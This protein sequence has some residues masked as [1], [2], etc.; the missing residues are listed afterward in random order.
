MKPIGCVLAMVVVLGGCAGVETKMVVIS[1]HA[2]PAS[3]TFTVIPVNLQDSE[4]EQAVRI[5]EC[6]LAAG[7][8]VLERP[9]VQQVEITGETVAGKGKKRSSNDIVASFDA[10][11][12]DV[13]LVSNYA[14]RRV[15]MLLSGQDYRVLLSEVYEERDP[16][17]ACLV[18]RA[19]IDAYDIGSAS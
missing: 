18:V 6:L 19:A 5:Q 3:P 8:V 16:S 9:A 10:T 2:L 7:L 13:L 4:V 17:S 15:R 14:T 11:D 12:A 1:K